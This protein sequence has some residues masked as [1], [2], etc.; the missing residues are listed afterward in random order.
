MAGA[1]L[2]IGRVV[3]GPQSGG[4]GYR[5]LERSAGTE[6]PPEA[7][8]RLNALP[9]ALANWADTGDGAAAALI[10]LSDRHVPALLMR[11]AYFGAGTR[12]SVAYANGLV[13]DEAALRG[14]GGHPE[15][16]LDLIPM[17]ERAT[18]FAAAPLDATLEDERPPHRDW[19]GFALEWRDRLLLVSGE[20]E[21]E[22]T[23]RS[24]LNEFPL[25]AESRVRGWATTALL[26]PAG[27][28]SPA[29]DLQLIVV[30]RDRKRPGGL[31]YLEAVGTPDGPKGYRDAPVAL[32]RAAAAWEKLKSICSNDRELAAAAPL[33][34]WNQQ[35]WSADPVDVLSRA[36]AAVA[37]R[38][39]GEAQ[40][41]LVIAM[42]TPRGESD[43]RD[44]AAA[45]RALFAGIL[46][47][48]DLTPQHMAFYLK[49]LADAPDEATSALPE[50]APLLVREG[51]GRWLRGRAF[52]RLVELGYAEAL[53]D[54][55]GDP[56]PVL[57]GL[58]EDGLALLLERP[59]PGAVQS[60]LLRMLAN[61]AAEAEP[62]WRESFARTLAGRLAA[63]PGRDERLLARHSVVRSAHRYARAQ[64]PALSA[65]TL[66]LERARNVREFSDT[67]GGMLEWV[68]LKRKEG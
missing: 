67:L 30:E 26:A 42:A 1:T 41:R 39:G 35:D 65:R 25:S 20:E 11:M 36:A 6:L 7:E 44:F 3:L 64:M 31:H 66:R 34:R 18:D 61:G 63:P 17:P 52:E 21:I 40:M 23:L 53:S 60:T 5:V 59:L 32:T 12:G 15:R 51:T 37:R 55:E 49:A 19:S 54:R 14:T 33:L 47:V 50:P 9:Q 57:A 58:N 8:G 29:R 38:L 16:L 10:P 46:A 62:A 13:I 56:A 2:R 68:K 22:P 45:A 43:D 24:I 28:F 4:R 27:S 48:P